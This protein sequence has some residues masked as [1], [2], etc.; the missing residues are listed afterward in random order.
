[1]IYWATMEPTDSEDNERILRHIEDRAG[2]GFQTVECGHDIARALPLP[3]NA[4][5]LFDSITALLANEMF[6]GKVPDLRAHEKALEELRM[7]SSSAA[8]TVFVCDE[9]FRGGDRFGDLTDDYMRSL[10]L[11][12]R[13]TAEYC[14]AVCE[15]TAGLI[16]THKGVLPDFR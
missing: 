14:D 6:S 9:I 5:V 3:D 2:W 7:L 10:A 11:I 16:K 8:N 13:G 15:V 12:C 4:S 1:M